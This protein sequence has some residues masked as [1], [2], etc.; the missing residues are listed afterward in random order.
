MPAAEP[1]EDVVTRLVVD[2]WSDPL[3]VWAYLAE[4][5]LARLEQRFGDRLDLRWRTVPVFG[6]VS[7]RF[8]HGAWQGDGPVGRTAKNAELARLRGHPEVR[9]GCWVDDMPAT[10]WAPSAAFEAARIAEAEGRI[11]PGSAAGYLRALR[12]AFLVDG[13]NVARRSV[14]EAVAEA[15]GIPAAVLAAS[16]D[17][18]R[19]LAALWESHEERTRLGVQGS[20]TWVFDGGRAVLYGD[21][22]EGVLQATVEQLLAG[23][24]AG[25]STC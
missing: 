18:G 13:H 11:P 21:V 24:E 9:G 19:A 22:H 20:P 7:A 2:Y 15:R 12:H 25:C 8:A 10:T 14:Q 4:D 16:L 5:K 3:C 6:S 17:D 23:S 1:V